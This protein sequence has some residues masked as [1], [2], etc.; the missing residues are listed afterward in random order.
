M[1][2]SESL[3][4]GIEEA[5]IELGINPIDLATAISYE[6]SGT[7]DPMKLG[8]TTQWGQ[9]R[10]LIQFGEPQAEQHG[11][12]FS[13][14][15]AAISSQLGKDGAI[16]SYLRNAGVTP[17][18]SMMDI[19]SAINAGA[20]GLHNRSDAN[21][22]GAPGTVADKVNNQMAG[23]RS[24]AI[25]LFGSNPAEDS[26]NVGMSVALTEGQSV[27]PLEGPPSSSNTE[28]PV[29]SSVEG[30]LDQ[31][32]SNTLAAAGREFAGMLTPQ[33]LMMEQAMFNRALSQG[34]TEDFQSWFANNRMPMYV[35]T[36]QSGDPEAVSGLTQPQLGILAR[37]GTSSQGDAQTLAT[38]QQ[39]ED[40]AKSRFGR[41]FSGL[42]IG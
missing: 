26:P 1:A 9:H 41:A 31:T 32:R 15:E 30:V 12:D 21:S 24:N 27:G 25:A 40:E 37:L 8:P 34:E 33:Q 22:G 13:S 3:R 18:M 42:V 11:A 23:H 6:T 10:G 39:R 4:S 35:A 5:A 17:G 28:F 14:S 36:H 7:F 16:V 38:T 29:S 19:Y 20:P 2:F